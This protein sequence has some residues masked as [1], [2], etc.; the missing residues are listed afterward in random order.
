MFRENKDP[1]HSLINKLTTCSSAQKSQRVRF[2][3]VLKMSLLVNGWHL[4]YSKVDMKT[5]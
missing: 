2:H 3:I 4:R 1:I 5:D